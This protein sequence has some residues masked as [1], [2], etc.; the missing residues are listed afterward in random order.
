MVHCTPLKVITPEPHI[1]KN[2]SAIFM[3]MQKSF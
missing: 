3:E 2:A 1:G